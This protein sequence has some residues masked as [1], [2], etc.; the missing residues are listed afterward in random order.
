MEIKIEKREVYG[1]V[2]YYPMSEGAELL[3]SLAGKKTLSLNMLRTAE[4]LGHTVTMVAPTWKTQA[5][6]ISD[7]F[8]AN[9]RLRSLK[10]RIGLAS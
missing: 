3:A 6:E 4:A 2:R 10:R 9:L 8:Q 7:D 1:V 5:D